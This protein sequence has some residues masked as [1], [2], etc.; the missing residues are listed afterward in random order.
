MAA[1]DEQSGGQK[2]FRLARLFHTE[3]CYRAR[4]LTAEELVRREGGDAG[5]D[6]GGIGVGR[7]RSRAGRGVWIR[8]RHRPNC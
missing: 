7:G 8:F 5:G 3:D 2:T 4:A 6:R 1:H